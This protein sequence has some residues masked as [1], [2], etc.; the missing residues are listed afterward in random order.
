MAKAG[1][2]PRTEL[3]ISHH[4]IRKGRRS[5]ASAAVTPCASE[6]VA[7]RYMESEG[8][9]FVVIICQLIVD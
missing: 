9:S 3:R 4:E 2:A 1:M 8:R 6:L 5:L 7:Y